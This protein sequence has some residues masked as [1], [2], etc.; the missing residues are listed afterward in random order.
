MFIYKEIIYI[1]IDIVNQKLHIAYLISN[2]ID[3]IFKYVFEIKYYIL[4]YKYIYIY[5]KLNISKIIVDIL[6]YKLYIISQIS[7]TLFTNC[8]YI[9]CILYYM[10]IYAYILCIYISYIKYHVSNN[11]HLY[12]EYWISKIEN[13]TFYILFTI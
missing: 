9:N 8:F 1:D 2:I 10:Y 11:L 5:I 4:N 12:I 6:C 7:N 13:F 3:C